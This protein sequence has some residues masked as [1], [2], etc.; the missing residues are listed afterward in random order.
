MLA[1][2]LPGHGDDQGEPLLT[3]EAM[4]MWVAGEFDRPATVVG[5]SLGGLIALELTRI[6]PDLVERL[7][8]SGTSTSIEVNAELQEAADQRLAQAVAMIVG[9]SYDSI[10]RLGGHPDP[11][12]A[13]SIVTGRLIESELGNLGTDLRA[14]ASYRRGEEAALGIKVPTLVIAGALD[15]MVPLASVRRLA[16]A[17]EGAHLEILEEAGHM[18]LTDSPNQV[19]GLL[20]SVLLLALRPE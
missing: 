5:H 19:R 6:R 14:T 10:A 13:P 12:I 16:A 2:D 3:V 18:M 1:L 11:G 15:R 17:I 20:A 8:L 9:W 7:V 4:A